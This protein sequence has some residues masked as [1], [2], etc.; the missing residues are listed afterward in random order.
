MSWAQRLKRV[1]KLHLT[2]CEGC[3]G[4]VRVIP[5]IDDSG[6]IAKILAHPE[7]QQRHSSVTTVPPLP[8]RHPSKG[9]DEIVTVCS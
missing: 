5:C 9:S 7:S 4:Q 6:V 2:S 1:F 3:G 8:T